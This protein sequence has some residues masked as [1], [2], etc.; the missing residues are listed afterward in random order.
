MQQ[1]R[2]AAHVTLLLRPANTLVHAQG[3]VLL[4][5]ACQGC[6]GRAAR[7]SSS[8][9]SYSSSACICTNKQ[10]SCA[11]PKT[12]AAG[13]GGAVVS[14][15]WSVTAGRNRGVSWCTPAHVPASSSCTHQTG[16]SLL[17]GLVKPHEGLHSHDV[18]RDFAL[19]L[20]IADVPS[21]GHPRV[22][23]RLNC[24][25]RCCRNTSSTADGR[26]TLRP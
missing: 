22:G 14:Q 21:W 8:G 23:M 11:W 16:S 5:A 3:P 20:H 26:L 12:H 25:R 7:D 4:P 18:G 6:Q 19:A 9:G 10:V 2:P 13:V 15:C 24:V 1:T 17:D